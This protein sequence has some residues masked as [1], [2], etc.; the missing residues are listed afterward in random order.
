MIYQGLPE[1]LEKQ[2]P[3]LNFRNHCYL[4]IAL[5]NTLKTKWDTKLKKPAYKYLLPHQLIAVINLLES[6]Q[7]SKE[8]LLQHNRQ[9]LN[10][11]KLCKIQQRLPF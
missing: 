11:R 3:E 1:K 7:K 6:Y 10:Y 9:S 4:R 8:V 2:Y 5:D